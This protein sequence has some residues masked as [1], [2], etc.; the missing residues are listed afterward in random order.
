MR[1]A[2]PIHQRNGKQVPNPH[3]LATKPVVVHRLKFYGDPDRL[4]WIMKWTEK[5]RRL[6]NPAPDS[7]GRAVQAICKQFGVSEASAN[8]DLAGLR[9]YRHAQ[10]AAEL[11]TYASMAYQT[12]RRIGDK[13]EAAGDYAA[14][15]SAQ[16]KLLKLT[17]AY[18]PMKVDIEHTVNDGP[19]IQQ[20]L[21]AMLGVLD[22]RDQVDLERILAKFEQAK[23]DGRLQLPSGDDED[24]EQEP[25]EVD[26]ADDAEVVG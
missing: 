19:T 22:H 13:A 15:V 7:H 6:K 18:A 25:E 11:P 10:F 17:G 24:D 1:I 8:K 9:A 14:A 4:R 26:D 3:H 20:Q 12:L 16:D 2:Q 5:E 23:Q 21:A